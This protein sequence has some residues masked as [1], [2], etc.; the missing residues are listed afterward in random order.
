MT[1]RDSTS[2][3]A[4]QECGAR[5]A[6]AVAR[7]AALELIGCARW[8][9]RRRH[10]LMARALVAYAEEMELAADGGGLNPNAD[11][12]RCGSPWRSRFRL[13]GDEATAPDRS[14]EARHGWPTA[15]LTAAGSWLR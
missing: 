1:T 15:A 6:A 12:T 3:T 2:F 9:N 13:A 8:W 11:C 14:P 5:T 10:R 4:G 7:F